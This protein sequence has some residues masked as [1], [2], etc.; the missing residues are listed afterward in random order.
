MCKEGSVNNSVLVVDD[1]VFMRSVLVRWLHAAGYLPTDVPDATT[2]LDLVAA[3]EFDVVLVD[4]EMP[5]RD[6]LWLVARL[7]E[8]FPNVAVVLA[9]AS[10]QIPPVISMQDGVVDYLV[11]PFEL[12]RVID[13]VKR[14]VEWRETAVKRDSR[15]AEGAGTLDD[16]LRRRT[17]SKRQ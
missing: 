4:V 5:G 11:K 8:R 14:A 2:A 1:N 17:S 13:A 6:G 7:R 9:T 3:E 10:D 16:W 15:R 12:D